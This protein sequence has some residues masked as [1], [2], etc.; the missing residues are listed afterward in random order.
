M[1]VQ[2]GGGKHPF[3]RQR[4]AD[5]KSLC[6]LFAWRK[7]S[8]PRSGVRLLYERGGKKK[9]EEAGGPLSLYFHGGGRKKKKE[10]SKKKTGE[11]NIE[12]SALAKGNSKTFRK[13]GK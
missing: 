1:S 4:R 12:I 3:L 11:M 6:F 7:E 13:G 2:K 9:G 5:S 10:R 8:P